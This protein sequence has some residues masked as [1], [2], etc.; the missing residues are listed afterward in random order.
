[1]QCRYFIR[2][3]ILSPDPKGQKYVQCLWCKHEHT[4]VT[5]KQ[6]Q[7]AVGGP[8]LKCDGDLAQCQVPEEFRPTA[9][10]G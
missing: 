9:S 3:T 5:R 6:A 7:A 1:M 4:P 2:E 8:L 10:V